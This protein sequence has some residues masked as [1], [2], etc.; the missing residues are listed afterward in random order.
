MSSIET[1]AGSTWP[2]SG[3]KIQTLN[4]QVSWKQIPRQ[5]ESHGLN[6]HWL[7]FLKV[8]SQA[9][10]SLTP[11]YWLK[12]SRTGTYIGISPV[13]NIRLA[14]DLDSCYDLQLVT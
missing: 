9:E 4:L 10:A 3:R 14:E 13:S 12:P 7:W 2:Q 11:S 8:T 5:L 1:R 6:H